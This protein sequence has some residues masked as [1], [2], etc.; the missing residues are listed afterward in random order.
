MSRSVRFFFVAIIV[1]L[2]LIFLINSFSLSPEEEVVQPQVVEPIVEIYTLTAPVQKKQVV[3]SN[4]ISIDTYKISELKGLSYSPTSELPMPAGTLFKRDIPVGTYLTADDIIS[5]D[6]PDYLFFSLKEDELPYWY[7]V[8]ELIENGALTVTSGDYVS[9]MLTQLSPEDDLPIANNLQPYSSTPLLS[10]MVVKQVKVLKLTKSEEEDNP[11]HQLAL[12]LTLNE[13][14]A[15]ESA[16]IM[17]QQKKG[18]LK[19]LLTSNVPLR[20]KSIIDVYRLNRD[21]AKGQ[22][23][24][25]DDLS[26]HSAKKS[27]LKMPYNEVDNIIL[28]D[29]AVF[30]EDL[31][32]DAIV[33]TEHIANTFDAD[34]PLFFLQEGELPYWFD[35]TT[36]IEDGAFAAKTGDFVS[37]ILEVTDEK[38]PEVWW[39]ES[40]KDFFSEIIIEKARVLHLN[41]TPKSQ[42]LVV[43]LNSKN[44]LQLNAAKSMGKVDVILSSNLKEEKFRKSYYSGQFVPIDLNINT[45]RGGK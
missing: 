31:K 36:L 29:G 2:M 20:D 33:S 22:S 34:Y 38:S 8:T 4:N 35:V 3:S 12:A 14:M 27:E 30:K 10:N 43:A 37:F 19:L 44:I 39:G 9:F 21:V 15:L 45:L 1:F 26:V 28:L 6:H 13:I 18:H 16:M 5:L 42:Q 25:R 24:D 23:I 7:D 17:D 11:R 40:G 32:A 41:L